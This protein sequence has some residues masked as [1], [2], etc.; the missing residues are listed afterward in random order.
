MKAATPIALLLLGA[1]GLG[2]EV[3]DRIAVSIGHQV[4]TAADLEREVRVSAFLNR[5]R[6][7][8]SPTVKRATAGRMVEQRLVRR[9][10]DIS[11]YPTPAAADVEPVLKKLQE[12]HYPSAAI[13]QRALT[14]YGITD[15]EVREH[16]LWQLTLLRFVEVRFRPAVSIADEAVSQ[17]FEKTVKATTP[18][19][20]LDDYRERIVNI[21]TEQ[22]MDRDLDI[23]LREA[24]RRNNIE[25]RQEVFQ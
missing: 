2:A 21:L 23:W 24:K 18:Q 10:L 25:Y 22:Q 5:S 11:R 6:L 8:F 14:E 1:A 4:I 19:A 7:D 9:E 15:G 20:T 3:I 12:D 16:I 17:Y 13:Y